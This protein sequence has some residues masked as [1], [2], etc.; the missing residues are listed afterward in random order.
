MAAQVLHGE[1]VRTINA[2]YPRKVSISLNRKTATNLGIVFP[3]EVLNLAGVIY[4]DYEGKQ[5]IRK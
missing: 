4:D 5:V 2:Q 1:D 3:M